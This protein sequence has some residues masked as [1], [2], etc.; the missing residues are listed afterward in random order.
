MISVGIIGGSGYLGKKL[1]QFCNEHPYI[2]DFTV[3]ANTTA[4]NNLLSVFPEFKGFVNNKLILPIKDISFSHDVYFFALPH[5][6]AIK[7]IP[8]L[9]SIGKKVIDLSGDFRLDSAADYE[10]WYGL[11]HTAP[12]LLKEKLYGLADKKNYYVNDAKLI[13]NPGCYPTAALLSVLPLVLKYGS[14]IISLSIVAYSGT[15]GAGKSPKTD[16]LL[17]E[18]DGNVKAYNVHKHRH[19]PEILQELKKN[20]FISH[21]SF[22]THLLPIS[23]GIYS[24]SIA[25]L[26][27]EL[28]H[29]D[30]IDVYEEY[31]SSS[32]FVRLRQTP[33]E[34]NWVVGTNFCDINVS[35]K[36]NSVILTSAIDNLI[37]GGAG[38]AIQNMNKLFKWEEFTGLIT[39]REKDVSVY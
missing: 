26:S 28:K 33:P 18:M 9:L 7:L 24:T 29:E 30:V 10:K 14:E 35:V 25:H 2:D 37:K 36:G 16:L 20:G 1:I 32:H 4:G 5:G 3:Y 39:K 27:T 13:A 21:F 17:S 31:Y 34:L 15:S 6:E 11:E 12:N 23:V 38:Q 19:E 22:T 8:S